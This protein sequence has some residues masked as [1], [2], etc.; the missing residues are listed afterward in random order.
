M[1]LRGVR[2]R[3]NRVEFLLLA[4][5]GLCAGFSGL[6]DKSGF[7]CLQHLAGAGRNQPFFPA[8]TDLQ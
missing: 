2:F 8:S 3:V 4:R 5:K 6:C 1:Q 7:D